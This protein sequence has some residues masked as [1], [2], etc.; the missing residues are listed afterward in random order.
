[1]KNI[2]VFG[3][4]EFN[5]SLM[6]SLEGKKKYCFHTLFHHRDVNAKPE[7]RVKMLYEGAS[8]QLK[9]Y[10]GSVDAIVGYWDFP[11]STMLPLLRQTFDLPSPSFEAVLKCE[12]KFWSRTEQQRVIPEYI[13]DFCAVDPFI[14]APRQQ[15]SLDYPFWIKPVKAASS[16]LGF[17]VHNDDDFKLAINSIR[18]GIHRFA[19]PF[20]YLLQYAKIPEDVAAIDGYHCIAEE[21][22]SK[23]RQCT[24]EGYVYH[25]E[26]C[27]YGTVDSIREGKHSSSFS[28]Y[29]YPSSIP[30]ST[31]E[32][33][34]TVTERFLTH[35]GFDNGP[36]NIEF[37]WDSEQDKIWLLEINTRISKSH[38]PLFLYVDGASHHKVMLELALGKRPEFPHRQG[39]YRYAAKFMWRKYS[40]AMVNKVPTKQEIQSICSQVSGCQMQMNI[41]EGMLLSELSDQD[42]YSYE[43]AVIFV[44]GNS[45]QELLQKY[46]L[47]QQA[48]P[49][50]L[51]PPC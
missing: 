16:Y 49:L 51:V 6:R 15:I 1:M 30:M 19:K 12:H 38:C 7:I 14:D 23:G 18:Q 5:L 29:Q 50:D 17:M 44:A 20:N 32:K 43:I 22:I 34:I 2:F 26:L 47:L 37:Y 27:V 21:I 9:C 48:M 35:I 33:M 40:D 24:M 45:Q 28:R 3:A 25:G 13:P 11:V 8:E 31:Q 36:F 42:S 4:D 39:R 46:H 41:K 10:P